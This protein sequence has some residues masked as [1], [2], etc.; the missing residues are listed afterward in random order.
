MMNWG[1]DGMMGGWGGF[2]GF[3]MIFGMIF[4]LLF[5]AGFILLIVWAIRQFAPGRT[6]STPPPQS[7]ALKILEE[8]FAKGEITE[9]EFAE[10]KRALLK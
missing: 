8:R 3:G 9:E 4:M 6:P 10:M 5:W 1:G 2:S 7:N